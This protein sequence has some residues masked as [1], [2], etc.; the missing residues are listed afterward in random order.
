MRHIVILGIRPILNWQSRY[1]I[2]DAF[3]LRGSV[4]SGF[5]APSLAQLYYNLIFTDNVKGETVYS[6][7]SANNSTITKAFGIVQLKEEKA[8]NTSIGFAY[9]KKGFTATIDAYSISVDDR[10]ILTDNFTDK[11]VLGPLNSDRA[12]FFANGVDTKTIGLD[13]VLNYK[14][15]LSDKGKLN[16]GVLGN[17]NELDIKKIHNKNLNKFTF[18]GPFSQ[19][20]LKAAAPDYKFGLNLGYNVKK[21]NATLSLTQ[22]SKV[23]IQDYHWVDSPV[24]TQAE[25][26]AL[27]LKATDVY[28][29]AIVLDASVGYELFKGLKL[30]IG[31]NNLLNQYPTPQ[32]D[33]WTD[34]GGLMDSVQMGSDGAYIFSRL[35][36][37]F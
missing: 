16:I 25:A 31:A 24:T 26:D 28:K 30:I 6:L 35:N 13:I 15:N 22:F 37:S 12:Q 36:F 7:L 1:N 34:Q 5:R 18:F 3:A 20:Y 33:G 11:K 10:V 14:M 23:T 17:I 8:I 2:S 9:N 29:A 32:T 4:S 19:A 21:F 27:F